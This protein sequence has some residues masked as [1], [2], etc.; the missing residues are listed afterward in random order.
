VDRPLVVADAQALPFRAG[1]F[2]FVIASHL[3]E[4]VA[5]P[6]ALCA[7]LARVAAAGYVETPSPA[8]E[9]VFPERNHRW[10]VRSLG[11]GRL[12]FEPNV[13]GDDL[14]RRIGRLAYRWYYAGQVKEHP[15]VLGRSAVARVAALASLVL[16]AALNR[17]GVA[18][19]RCTFDERTPLSVEVEADSIP[20]VLA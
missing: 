8:F 3:A 4:H 15:T 18:V 10:R 1:S 20:E 16:R 14:P 11:D 12:R 2:G 7:E 9:R 17:S 13:Q 6:R 5:D 19:S